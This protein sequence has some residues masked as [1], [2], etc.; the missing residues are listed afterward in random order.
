MRLTP[1]V[2][3]CFSAVFFAISPAPLARAQTSPA[4]PAKPPST[5]PAPKTV[6]V[7]PRAKKPEP[8]PEP[9]RPAP[10]VALAITAPSPDAAWTMR[11]EN[12]GTVPLHVL[13]DASFLSLEV[14]PEG[15]KRSVRCSLPLEMRP[16][17]ADDRML[18][19]PP[20]R[21]YSEKFDPRVFCFNAAL[22]PG[23]SVVAHLG[24]PTPARSAKK[25]AP[26][27]AV[28][29]IDG[30]E[31]QVSAAK[32][33][34]SPAATI[35]PSSSTAKEPDDTR[36]LRVTSSAAIDVARPMDI[37]L[38]VT[39][40]NRGTTSATFLL[41]PETIA[42]DVTGPSGIGVTDPSPSVRCEAESMP[43]TSIR[44]AFTTLAPKQRTSLTVMVSVLCPEHT[45]DQAGLYMVRA[46]L[47]TRRAS[48]AGIGLRTFDGD[49]PADKATRVRVREDHG[50]GAPSPRPKLDEAPRA[51]ATP[52]VSP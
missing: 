10:S 37:A 26:P 34:A 51:Q 36:P 27:Y 35:G 20:G 33:I 45:F 43:S 22:A 32:E 13:A 1:L 47:D 38:P 50:V 2:A 52:A 40:T 12:T 24:W 4:A 9:V 25:L 8:P 21:S 11:V 18:V 30:L 28:R 29:P 14:T 49:V 16:H 7:K 39:I 17:D 15:A 41:R 48:G 5:A 46:R 44:D 3:C 19:I 23:A 31:P 42:L 6:P